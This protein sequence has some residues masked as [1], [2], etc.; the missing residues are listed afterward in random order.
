MPKPRPPFLHS[1]RTRHGVLVWYVRRRHGPRIR[2]RA[3]Y[4]TP[5]FWQ[6]YNTAIAGAPQPPRK[7]PKAHTLRWALDRYRHSS[8][9]AGLSPATRRQ[10]ENIFKRVIATAGD[11]PLADIDTLAIRD[12][13]ERRAAK[14]HAA[15]TFV[16]AMRTFCAWCVE[17]QLMTSNPAASVKLLAG[18][19]DADG[20]HTWTEEELDR[21]EARWAVGTRERLA[22]DLLLYTGLRRGDAVRVGKQHVR[23]GVISLRTEKHRQGKAGELVT[24]PILA[25][26]E[27]SLAATTTGDLTFLVNEWGQPWV[28]ESFGNW[29]RDVCRKAKCPGSAHGLRKAGATRAAERG[30]SERQLMAIFGW[31]TG[32]MAQHYTRA[33]DRKHLA[34]TAAQMLLPA[35][36]TNEK[37]PHLAS[38]A[39][40]KP[41][42]SEKSGA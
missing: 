28:K 38:G 42:R 25:P 6:E 14:P 3:T 4:D 1:E 32:K 23:D 19:N 9:W 22:F 33:A 27:A 12:G 40:G 30:A 8:A 5:A 24:I 7:S 39:G 16:K 17:E 20:F 37:R 31:T 26:L 18:P 29:F 13:R 10:R 2:L 41:D 36:S 11:T 35:Q 21:F 34:R 15:N